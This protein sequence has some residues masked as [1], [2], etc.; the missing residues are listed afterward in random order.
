MRSWFL[1][2][3]PAPSTNHAASRR[4]LSR[5]D[6]RLAA[7]LAAALVLLSLSTPRNA[8]GQTCPAGSNEVHGTATVGDGSTAPNTPAICPVP[9][10]WPQ[11]CYG[12]WGTVDLP[13]S[14]P[15]TYTFSAGAP[16]YLSP[17]N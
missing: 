13:L 15:G 5:R 7:Y 12:A 14:Y 4:R 16:N 10:I 1:R 3:M 8:A 11:R 9:L 6:C 17:P 2:P